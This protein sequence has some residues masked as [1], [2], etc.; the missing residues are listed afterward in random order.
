MIRRNFAG[1]GLEVSQLGLGTVKLGRDK[2]VKY[3]SGF[4]IPSDQ[5]ALALIN[6]A[7]DLGINLIDTAPAYGNSEERL[8]Q[9]LKGQ[10]HEWLICSKVGE[11]FDSETG[12]SSFNFTPEHVRYSVERSLQRLNTDYIDMLLV[13]SDGNDEEIIRRYGI[14]Q[15]LQELKAEGK[16][17]VTG[18]STKTVAGGLLALSQSDCAMV[19]YNLAHREEEPVL[20]Y[21]AAEG[22]GI[23]LKKALASGHLCLDQERDPVAASFEFIFAHPGVSSAIVGTINPEHLKANVKALE[24]VSGR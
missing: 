18:M 2:G 12:E 4:K 6:L 1:T 15:Q 24:Q 22:K 19:T 23:L 14:L 17:R 3:P 13:H 11:E 20:D 5:E 10:R 21:A 9:L 7:R 8:G 16:I